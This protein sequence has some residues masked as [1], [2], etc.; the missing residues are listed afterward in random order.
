MSTLD[1]DLVRTFVAVA[2]RGSFNA[3]AARVW[4]SQA[5]VS[6]QIQRLEA[7]L[8]ETLLVRSSR[9]VRL[10]PSG[11]R[12]LVYA[13][14]LLSLSEEAAAAARGQSRTLVR[15]GAPDDIAAYVL[16]P[17]LAELRAQRPDLAFEI[18]TGSTREL[19]PLLAT[20]HDVV[21]G[22][23]LP[24]NVSG[25]ALSSMPLRWAGDWS[26]RGAV[27]LALYPE[28]CVMRGQALAALDAA[29]VPWEIAISASAVTVVEAAARTRLAVGPVAV[30]LSATDLPIPRKLPALPR[31]ELRM[32]VGKS[33]PGFADLL[34]P[35]LRKRLGGRTSR[36]SKAAT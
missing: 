24:G 13:H 10:S 30:G 27:P 25:Q 19:L 33:D 28:G 20:R 36:R 11:E 8:G 2:E 26:G 9:E 16:M 23:A 12:F 29:G 5:A 34:A 31:V 21:L 22:I 6:Q 7:Q 4:R 14:R 15:I 35:A 1:L 17:V 3:A 32:F 18:T